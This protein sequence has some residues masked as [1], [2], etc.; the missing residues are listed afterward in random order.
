MVA[1][2]FSGATVGVDGYTVTVETDVTGGLPCFNIVGLPDSAVKESR[3]RV[4]V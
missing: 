4:S 2:V 3:E 1:K